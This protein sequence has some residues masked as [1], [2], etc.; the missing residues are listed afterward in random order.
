VEHENSSARLC[1]SRCLWKA[2]SHEEVLRGVEKALSSDPQNIQSRVLRGIL[3]YLLGD[4]ELSFQS[5]DKATQID[6]KD[7]D[8]W[9]DKALLSLHAKNYSE[10]LR[11]IDRAL[12]LDATHFEAL[13]VRYAF[14]RSSSQIVNEELLLAPAEQ[15]DAA[16]Y[17]V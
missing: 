12:A 10:A 1:K 3:E 15:A 16:C 14:D 17:K 7:A 2:G 5:F 6:N 8:L 11:S 9:Y 4:F 13:I